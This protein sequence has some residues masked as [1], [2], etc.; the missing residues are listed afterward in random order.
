VADKEGI[1]PVR[2][3]TD[4][5]HSTGARRPVLENAEGVPSPLT[6]PCAQQRGSPSGGRTAAEITRGR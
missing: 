2:F 4:V 6:V 5:R 3:E 1:E